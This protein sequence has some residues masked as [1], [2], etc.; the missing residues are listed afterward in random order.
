[1]PLDAHSEAAVEAGKVPPP[2]PEKKIIIERAA[3]VTPAITEPTTS[4]PADTAAAT[5]AA[6]AAASG[7]N[8][9]FDF[10]AA[11]TTSTDTEAE[12]PAVVAPVVLESN[13]CR[14]CGCVTCVCSDEDDD[15]EEDDDKTSNGGTAEEV[16]PETAAADSEHEDVEGW[17]AAPNSAPDAGSDAEDAAAVHVEDASPAPRASFNPF[18]DYL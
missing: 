1:L 14:A 4:A 11:F 16:T 12:P 18:E 2:S 3:P 15:E 5:A 7:F 13:A 6:A 9:S 17:M 8:L 10:S